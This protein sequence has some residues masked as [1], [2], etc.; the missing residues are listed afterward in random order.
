MKMLFFYNPLKFFG[1][2]KIA[3]L[4]LRKLAIDKAKLFQ[5][6]HEHIKLNYTRTKIMLQHTTY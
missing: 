2:F 6:D 1:S 4:L 3:K 5:K